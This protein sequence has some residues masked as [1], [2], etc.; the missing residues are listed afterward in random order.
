M[1]VCTEGVLYLW[2]AFSQFLHD[3]SPWGP[4]FQQDGPVPRWHTISLHTTH[5]VKHR[6]VLNQLLGSSTSGPV[7]MYRQHAHMFPAFCS[8]FFGVRCLLVDCKSA[9]STSPNGLLSS[10][11]S[12]TILSNT[13]STTAAFDSST[14]SARRCPP[15]SKVPPT[16]VHSESMTLYAIPSSRTMVTDASVPRMC[17]RTLT[18]SGRTVNVLSRLQTSTMVPL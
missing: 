8:D 4:C 10:R 14:L 13:E 2:S 16:N 12:D 18:P 3:G 15:P 11:R 17:M 9:A 6:L 5:L 7:P 1:R